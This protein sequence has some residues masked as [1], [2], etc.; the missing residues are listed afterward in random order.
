MANQTIKASAILG[1]IA[2]LAAI[3]TA[4]NQ[5]WP[6]IGWTTP[7][8]HA[9]D[10][11]RLASEAEDATQEILDAIKESQ[12]EWKCDEYDEELTDLLEKQEA[13]DD[14]I[15]LE[16]TIEKIREAM[17]RRDCARFEDFG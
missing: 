4:G 16:R 5:F 3:G 11:E 12:D 15:E 7:N 6:T 2:T 13:G 1:V 10:V 8:A 17:Q 9:A 14:S